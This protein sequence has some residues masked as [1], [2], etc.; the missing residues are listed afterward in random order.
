VFIAWINGGKEVVFNGVMPTW[1]RLTLIA[2][3]IIPALVPWRQLRSYNFGDEID[4][5]LV[6]TDTKADRRAFDML[7]DSETVNTALEEIQAEVDYAKE[8]GDVLFI[9]QRQLL[10][11]G[12]ITDVPF[13]PEYEKK[14]LMNEALSGN[15]DYFSGF[16]QN[17]TDQRFSLIVTEPL[18]TPVKDSTYEFGEENNAWVKWV[19]IP[20]LC[21]YQEIQTYKEVNVML[22]VPK[23]VP[24]DCS[25]Y[26]P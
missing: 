3:L 4:T 16:Y 19:S 20:V 25:N 5:L 9:D 17:I 21:Y 8:F 7:P 23:P 22:L 13:I 14:M 11:F 15:A 12:Y 10:T 26:M 2:S 6:L 24:D 18:R 1:V